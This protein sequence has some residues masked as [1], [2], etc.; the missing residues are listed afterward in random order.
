MITE[1]RNTKLLWRGASG[2]DG[3]VLYSWRTSLFVILF[4]FIL[5]F[6]MFGYFWDYWRIADMD[7]WMVYNAFLL[8][9][10]LRQEY[11]DHPGYLTIISLASWLDVLH[12]VGL[13]NVHSLINLP[14]T[15]DVAAS[16]MAWAAAIKAARVLS[17]IIAIS[18]IIS[19]AY[20]LRFVTNNWRVAIMGA[21]LLA[22]SGGFAMESR[23]VR[24]E[25]ISTEFAILALLMLI[26]VAKRGSSQWRPIVI[27]ISAFLS[28]LAVTN[29]IHILFLVCAIPVIVY[30]FGE[31]EKEASSFWTKSRWSSWVI[32]IY[33]SLAILLA[34][35]VSD[36]F[37]IGLKGT[38]AL[39]FS[40]TSVSG[41]RRLRI[42]GYEGFYQTIIA[43]WI[44][45]WAL[46]Y[47]AKYKICNREFIASVLSIIAGISLGLLILY[48]HFD[49][50]NVLVVINPIEQMFAYSNINP[51]ELNGDFT[52]RLSLI[53]NLLFSGIRT[54][55]ATRTFVFHSSARPTIF[56][57]WIVV[58]CIIY[59]W[60]RGDRRTAYQAGILLISAWGI[61]LIGT[62]RTLK[63]EYFTITDPLV[64]ISAAVLFS[65]ESAL[66]NHRLTLP[67]GRILIVLTVLVGLAEP[68]KHSFKKGVPS[69]LCAP[70][71]RQTERIEHLPFCP[72]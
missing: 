31:A 59:I 18:F 34:W 70:H 25:L 36:I 20:L 56:L 68:V 38:E 58:A 41:L 40:G 57:E 11:F 29:K 52:D 16:A 62:V 50:K 19:F 51:S 48:L 63:Q 53:I 9:A 43:I 6:F 54:L 71:F 60:R 21:F 64:I 35:L 66:R 47:K 5:T 28:A 49:R 15:S 1:I 69:D 12:R 14:S 22:F 39:G 45:I 46:A 65:K 2:F 32:L 55:V 27:G 67:I 8:N 23:I 33:F 26:A 72:S 37:I 13:L 30:F 44:A 61:D 3:L 7:I 10:G 4:G 42:L 17:L 24:T